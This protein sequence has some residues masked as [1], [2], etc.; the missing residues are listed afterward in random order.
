MSEEGIQTAKAADASVNT[1]T[2]KAES[3]QETANGAANVASEADSTHT[4]L[5]EESKRYKKRALEAEKKMEAFEKAKLEEQGKYRELYE[6][7]KTQFEELKSQ[8]MRD[9]VSFEVKQHAAKVGCVDVNALLKLGRSDLM[10]FD[11]QTGEIHGV[12]LFIEDAKKTSPYLFK[13][14]P[15]PTINPAT[16]SGALDKPKPAKTHGLSKEEWKAQLLQAAKTAQGA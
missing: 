15:T 5:L 4:R 14:Q 2:V 11:E 10:Q 8:T 7:Y 9:K 1:E 12:D 16:P 13:T 3:T 6:Q